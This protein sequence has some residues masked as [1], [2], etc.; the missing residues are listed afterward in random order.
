MLPFFFKTRYDRVAKAVFLNITQLI[1]AYN[2]INN[3]EQLDECRFTSAHRLL[4]ESYHNFRPFVSID[5]T[6]RIGSHELFTVKALSDESKA[7]RQVFLGYGS[8]RTSRAGKSKIENGR[9]HSTGQSSQLLSPDGVVSMH[10]MS[11]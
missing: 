4:R 8:S 1:Q 11:A 6:T 3:Q 2:Q 7:P 5:S 10:S 9:F